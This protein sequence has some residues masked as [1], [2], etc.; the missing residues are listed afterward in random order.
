[1]RLD[2]LSIVLRPRTPWEAMDLGQALVREHGSA[3][4]RSWFALTLPFL[5]VCNALAWWIGKPWL[6]LLAMW[7]L[8]PLFE[9]APL[10]VLSRAVF[11]QA[12]GVRE[13]L[14]A[15]ELWSPGQLLP[16]LT[17]RRLHPARALLM[18]VD[19]LEGLRG[20]R[21]SQRVAVLQGAVS[22]QAFGLLLACLSFEL[23]LFV[24]VWVLALLFRPVTNPM[25]LWNFAT[26]LFGMLAQNPADWLRVLMNVVSWLALSLVGPFYSGSGFGLY[27]N[28][29]TQLEAWDVE[30]SFRRLAERLRALAG[31][32]MLVL[33]ML[34]GAT[35]SSPALAATEKPAAC[36]KSCLDPKAVFGE[37]WRPSD[38]RQ[39]AAAKTLA[40]D[41]LLSPKEK[42][43]RWVLR[44]PP[45]L[46]QQD[47]K[48]N[49][50]PGWLPDIAALFAM[51]G[52]YG[53]WVIAGLLLALLLWQLPRWL[54]WVRDRLPQAPALDPIEEHAVRSPERLPDDI[55]AAAR[56]LW[57]RQQRR[58]ALA[59]LYRAGVAAI[60]HALGSPLP[61]GAT[62]S[63][64]LRRSRRLPEGAL[65]EAFA[66]VVRLWQGAAY[67]QRLPDDAAFDALL[68]RWAQTPELMR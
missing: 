39:E 8:K 46:K 14:R 23:V 50:T 31:T 65:R 62:E 37:D 6:A 53:L 52:E 26:S 43:S 47:P 20:P 60:E 57:S 58:D 66:A 34:S 64:C 61:P 18:P 38:S 68:Q 17:W 27:L 28:R 25:D 49:Q 59:L 56:A 16:W 7:W 22:G 51:A 21:R 1:M 44:N 40:K 63:E 5:L 12:P 35:L 19:M 2:R 48:K 13:T 55:V 45:K 32:A 67:A 9:R 4:W 10:Y 15:K 29:R 30:L 42:V 24:S 41:P 36:E 54:P 33:L 11:G 3:V